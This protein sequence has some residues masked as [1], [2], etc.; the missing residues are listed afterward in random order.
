MVD[1]DSVYFI[2]Y[3]ILNTGNLVAVFFF[4]LVTVRRASA[5]SRQM[6]LAFHEYAI[7]PGLIAAAFC[8]ITVASKLAAICGM[9]MAY[10]FVSTVAVGDAHLGNAC[11]GP[12]GQS[13][14]SAMTSRQLSAV[15]LLALGGTIYSNELSHVLDWARQS[16]LHGVD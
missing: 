14:P 4:K 11:G 13:Q 5:A 16:D 9:L 6:K 7:N 8:A 10:A 15:A 3:V 12:F 1:A 2:V